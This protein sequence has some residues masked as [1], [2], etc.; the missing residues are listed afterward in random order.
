MKEMVGLGGLKLVSFDQSQMG[1]APKEANYDPW[2]LAWSGTVGRLERFI[3]SIGPA[4]KGF[5]GVHGGFKGLGELGTWF[6][7]GTH[8]G[9]E[10]LS[11]STKSM[12]GPAHPQVEC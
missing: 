11:S 4:S 1:H 12:P 6:G 10:G 5:A 7:D 3:S 2:E 9:A 8:G